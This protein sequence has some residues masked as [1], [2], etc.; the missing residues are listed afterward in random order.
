MARLRLWLFL[1]H[2]TDDSRVPVPFS[3]LSFLRHECPAVLLRHGYDFFFE[4]RLSRDSIHD[5]T[6]A[7]RVSFPLHHRACINYTIL[8]CLKDYNIFLVRAAKA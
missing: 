1:A 2:N 4:F 8:L 3:L 5:L 7:R 6:L